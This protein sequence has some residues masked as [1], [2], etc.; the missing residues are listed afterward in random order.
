[1]KNLFTLVILSGFYIMGLQAQDLFDAR[2]LTDSPARE[3]FPSWSS[4]GDSIVY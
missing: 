3:G 2:R 1:M 4:K